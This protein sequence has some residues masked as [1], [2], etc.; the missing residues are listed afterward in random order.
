M[1]NLA[2]MSMNQAM[3]AP[4]IPEFHVGDRLS[5]AREAAGLT[6]TELATEFGSTR[7]TVSRWETGKGVKRS[8][9]LAY[10][11]RTGV[12]VEWLESGSYNPEPP[13]KDYG[14]AVSAVLEFRRQK[15]A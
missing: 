10:S 12:P 4:V 15:A 2:R 8:V 14:S 3:N 9:L 7:S 5:K 6:Q 13:T 11:M 1:R